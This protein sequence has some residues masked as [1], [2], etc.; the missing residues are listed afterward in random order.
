LELKLHR[1]QFSSTNNDRYTWQ[2]KEDLEADNLEGWSDFGWRIE[3]RTLGRWFTPDPEDQFESVSTYAL[4]LNNPVSHIDPDGRILPILI[5]IIAGVVGGG[6]NVAT[7][8]SK[9]QNPLQA[10]GFFATGA[11][12][13][14]VSLGNPLA[15]GAITTAG[16]AAID[17]ASGN[18]PNLKNV[19]DAL[20]YIGKEAA[21]G[22]ATSFAG[23]QAGKI[24]GPALSKLGNSVG[25]W[26]QNSFQTYAK[27]SLQTV[28][29]NG[30]SITT[31][32]E[33]GIKATKTYV[34]K[35]LGSIGSTKLYRAVSKAE[36][37]DIAKNGIRNSP[38]YESGKLFATTAQDASNFGKLN[39]GFD[40][41]PFSIIQT[42]IPNKFTSQ[43]YKG[44]MDLMDAVSV[45]KNL[46]NKMAVPKT[47]SSTP[48][49]RHPWIK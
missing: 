25:G 49:P 14:V 43:L 39:Y 30:Q 2:G 6:L 34:S 32:I 41:E 29:I 16:N 5:P 9:I 28:I 27:E 47:L 10:L 33:A 45:P 11:A 15:G 40:K 13:G 24:I 17:I 22:A 46:F 35:A 1:Y 26:F 21:F 36:L 42:K 38:G 4:C 23:A 37:D 3:D 48:L 44:E 20:A 19:G 31:T 7:N 8:W 18:I 12:G